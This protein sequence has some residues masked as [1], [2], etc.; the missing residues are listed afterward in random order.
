MSIIHKLLLLHR[1]LLT[2]V[3]HR[4]HGLHNSSQINNYL[5]V[6][7]LQAINTYNSNIR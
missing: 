7:I 1:E 4:S 2:D 6:S 5:I 3:Q